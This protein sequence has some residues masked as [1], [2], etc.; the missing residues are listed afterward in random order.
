MQ[1]L[2]NTIWATTFVGIVFLS[3]A[4]GEDVKRMF[5]L[6]DDELMS[7]DVY[8]NSD[9]NNDPNA[10][11]ITA[12]RDISGPG[13]EFDIYF[14]PDNRHNNVMEYVSCKNRGKGTLVDIDVNDFDAFA[15]RFTLIAVDGK[16]DINAGGLL[17]V[18]ALVD[19]AYRPECISFAKGD[20]VISIT[21]N[22]V[23]KTSVIGFEVSKA[24]PDGWNPKGN[25]VTIRVEAAPKAEML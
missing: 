23:K 18:G 10:P 21:R 9:P 16:S 12:K 24:I 3:S 19:G 8:Q 6:S 5:T 14:P 1:I 13:V 4:I 15:L 17:G 20:E 11:F 25:T 2:K 22:H 7:I